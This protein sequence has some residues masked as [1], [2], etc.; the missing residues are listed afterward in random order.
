MVCRLRNGKGVVYNFKPPVSSSLLL[1]YLQSKS[2][3]I[4]CYCENFESLNSAQQSEMPAKHYK[5]TSDE[6]YEAIRNAHGVPFE[7]V[8]GGVRYKAVLQ[9]KETLYGEPW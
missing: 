9:H 6:L 7:F 1:L 5:I 4:I 2:F 8:T 3:S